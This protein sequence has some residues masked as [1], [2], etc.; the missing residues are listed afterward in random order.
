M[1]EQLLLKKSYGIWGMLLTAF[2]LLGT[3]K[4]YSQDFTVK[5]KVTSQEGESIPG[6]NVTVKN[7][8][9]GTVTDIDG[10][11]S[12]VVPEEN[13]QLVF[14]FI[15]YVAQEIPINGRS[16]IDVVMETDVQALEEVVIIG[17]GTVQKSDLTGSVGRVEMEDLIKA[18]VASFTDAL[19][20]RVAGVRVSGTDGQPGA[21][22]NIVIRGAGSLT[23]STSPLFVIDGFPIEDFD[24]TTLNPE[25]IESMTIL[26]DASSTAVYGSRAANGVILIQTKRGIVG[27]P[28]VSWNSSYGIQQNPKKMEMMSPYE[29]VKYQSELNPTSFNTPAYFANDRTLDYYRNVEGIDW[30][31]EVIRT[32]AVHIH[33]LAIRGGTEQT[34]YAISGSMY[35]QEGVIA[36]TGMS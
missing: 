34:K 1:K 25:D 11:Y 35:D 29:F 24:P 7:S 8:T 20:G 32:G 10:N 9:L 30:Q 19:A 6:A 12:L 3:M 26:K 27:K 4:G 17:Y 2:L 28:V 14:S 31:D 15:G 18:P 33:N 16:V 36:N 5:G 23:Q 22:M 21:E 13:Q